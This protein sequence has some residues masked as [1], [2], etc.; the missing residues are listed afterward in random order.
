MLEAGMVS[1]TFRSFS[2][3]K[4]IEIAHRANLKAI[5]WGG[6]KHV[7]PDNFENARKVGESTSKAGL[8]VAAYGSYFRLGRDSEFENTLKTAEHLG[9]KII[10]V[11]VGEIGS[12]VANAGYRQR[13]VEESKRI[14]DSA[15]AKGISIVYE[16]HGGTLTDSAESCLDLLEK[17]NRPNLKTYWQPVVGRSAEGNLKD[18]ELL[19]P[20]I[21]GVHVFHWFPT[22]A[23]RRL[24]NDGA[25]D[26]QKYL[27][28]LQ[29][30][31]GFAL[32]EFVK[33]DAL[34]NFSLDIATLKELL[35]ISEG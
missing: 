20:F 24:L 14:A 5:E 28:V 13:I 2:T 30:L 25:K 32:V 23:E 31:N 9:T 6:D 7:P 29:N 11:W 33:D 15:S 19:L 35:K 27:G 8:K 1:V 10:R 34:E 22:G 18:I 4:I 21:A 26:W 12:K 3:E 16:F 17:G